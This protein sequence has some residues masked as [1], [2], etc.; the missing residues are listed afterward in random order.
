[1]RGGRRVRNA[2]L[3]ARFR[4]SFLFR[5]KTAMNKLLLFGA[6]LGLMPLAARAEEP[7][8]FAEAGDIIVV[9][10]SD[11]PISVAPR[12]L[13]VSL[14]QEQFDAVNAVNVED[15]M[16]YAPNFFIRK[17]YIGDANGVAGFRGTHSTQSARSYVMVDGF[18]I[19]NFLGNSFGFPPKWG[20][21]GPGE[22]AQ[23]DILYGPY[24]ARYPGNS[25]GG[26]ISITTKEP[27][28]NEAFATAQYF[29]QPYEQY[30]TD[31]T[32]DGY[33]FEGGAGWRP[34]EG[35][36]A[37]RASYR[38][39]QNVGQPMS[40]YQ[41]GLPIAG[42][43]TPVTG[44]VVDPGLVVKA[45]IFAA[46]SPDHNTQDQFR[47]RADLDLGAWD[48]QALGVYWT[49]DSDRTHP[50]IYIRDA[51]GN[52]VASGNVS[53]GGRTYSLAAVPL[54][55]TERQEAL[56]GLRA[57]GPLFGWSTRFNLSHFWQVKDDARQSDTYAGGFASGSGKLTL[58]GQPNWTTFDTTFERRFGAHAIAVGATANLY[59][60]ETGVF[61]T[62]NWRSAANRSLT[63][64]TAGATRLIGVFLEDEI[65]LNDDLSLTIG[66][67]ADNWH[68][69]DGRVGRS[70]SSGFVVQS[71]TD[72]EETNVNG[73][74]S[75]QWE[76]APGWDAQLS[77]ATATRYPTVSELFQGVLLADGSFN[78]NSFD[79]NLR[80]EKSKDVNLIF[81]RDLGDVKVT[82]SIFYQEVENALFMQTGFN[83]FGVAYTSNQNIDLVRQLGAEA[84]VEAKDAFINGLDVDVNLAYI[85][86]VI[87]ENRA[88]P[89]SVG[90][91]FPRIPYWRANGS[92]R[93]ALNDQWRASAGFR[94]NTEPKSNLEGT[95]VGDT[96]GY[97]SEQFVLDTKL[98]WIPAEHREI[99]F[100]IDNINNDS[101]WAFHPF[102]QRTFM[103][104]AR[105]RQ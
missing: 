87:A 60:T 27:Q 84:I 10:Q 95:Q 3:S 65:T 28:N 98:T 63:N 12:G 20:V 94:Y 66:G 96:F 18:V 44:A 57:S 104:E 25:M 64:V 46:E 37:L 81:R 11:A 105:W 100:G 73:A 85:D 92:I 71:F 101:A 103:I 74:V 72:R 29:V 31:H 90:N 22:V 23:F 7:V 30:A 35:P 79:P 14:G 88:L 34:N 53:F 45:P 17:R 55:I 80:A 50:E 62:T 58:R 70:T 38:H 97:A 75:V 26:V 15:L 51:A 13:S 76:M 1:M 93:Y 6:A 77:L 24:S 40:W 21:V 48:V 43:G 89:A 61:N 69:Y 83:Q 5:V 86:A 19:S 39:F 4:T 59:E 82:G 67:R 56:V 54:A 2:S 41:M 47:L 32:Y 78:L 42:A 91:Q 52:P 9:G 36:F 16:K 49:T 102:P 8:Q 33:T 99:S 68:A